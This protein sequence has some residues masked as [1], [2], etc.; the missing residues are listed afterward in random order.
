MLSTVGSSTAQIYQGKRQLSSGR[1]SRRHYELLRGNSSGNKKQISYIYAVQV[2]LC[3]CA[4]KEKLLFTL[5][6]NY[7]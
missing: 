6:S 5:W 2:C 1:Q 4:L 7:S 3:D